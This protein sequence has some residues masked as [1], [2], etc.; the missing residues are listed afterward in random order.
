MQE[1]EEAGRQQLESLQQR[2][3]M[4]LAT[5]HVISSTEE[6]ISKLEASV[7]LFA[8]NPQAANKATVALSAAEQMLRDA[9]RQLQVMRASIPEGVIWDAAGNIVD[10]VD[11]TQPTQQPQVGADAQTPVTSIGAIGTSNSSTSSSTNSTGSTVI[12]NGTNR[13]TSNLHHEQVP[14]PAQEGSISSSSA[15]HRWKDLPEGSVIGNAAAD[16]RQ[17]T[18]GLNG[19]HH[20][21]TF[22]RSNGHVNGAMSVSS[23]NGR[24]NG[25]AFAGMSGFVH[26]QVVAEDGADVSDNSNGTSATSSPPYPHNAATAGAN[27]DVRHVN[28][29]VRHI[30]EIEEYTLGSGQSDNEQLGSNMSTTPGS[31]ISTIDEEDGGETH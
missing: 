17:H 1:Q 13:S 14:M 5:Q 23:A 30:P 21:G 7:G 4:L 26:V 11:P 8:N 10:F 19:A 18:S 15:A 24:T 9:R 27:G 22:Q 12:N 20:N 2:V 16:Q 28:G 31:A 25:N 6:N 29:T 3:R